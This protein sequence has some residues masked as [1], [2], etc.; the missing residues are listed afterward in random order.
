M[1][2]SQDPWLFTTIVSSDYN[3]V[4]DRS[5]ISGFNK[6]VKSGSV[7]SVRCIKPWDHDGNEN[8]VQASPIFRPPESTYSFVAT[9]LVTTLLN[10][11]LPDPQKKS[12]PL[13]QHRELNLI[14]RAHLSVTISSSPLG[15]WKR[16]QSE[17][18]ATR[19]F[20]LC[21]FRLVA[22]TLKFTTTKPVQQKLTRISL[23]CRRDTSDSRLE[24]PPHQGLML[25]E[26]AAA[27]SHSVVCG[28]DDRRNLVIL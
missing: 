20:F 3:P 10:L 18:T 12:A 13:I 14:L 2:A 7:F 1:R 23:H 17:C 25:L 26:I 16:K 19:I 28:K 15:N 11:S 21:G 27:S 8:L 24:M 6:K 4:L 5:Y 22:M 9:L